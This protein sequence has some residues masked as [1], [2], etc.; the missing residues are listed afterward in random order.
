MF[1]V[2]GVAKLKERKLKVGQRVALVDG[3]LI[4]YGYVSKFVEKGGRGVQVRWSKE[5]SSWERYYDLVPV[6]LQVKED[7]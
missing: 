4:F 7:Y 1:C 2:Q 6:K 3:E 5:H